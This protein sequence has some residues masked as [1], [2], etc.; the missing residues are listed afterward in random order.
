[1]V[2]K[3]TF[4]FVILATIVWASLASAFAGYYYLQNMNN[5]EQLNSA[6]SSLN[7]VASN[8]SQAADKYDLL[9]SEYAL[10][11]GNYSY[12]MGSNY[13]ILMP[14]LRSLIANFAKNYTS[15]LTQ[16][17]M[18][19]SYQQLLSDHATLLQKGNITRGDFG[20]LLSEYYNLFN[21]SAI[22]ELGLSISKSTTLSVNVVIDYGNGTAEWHNETIVTSGYT[23]FRLTQEIA[24]IESS[25]F[26]YLEPGHIRIDS[27]NGKTTTAN[28]T[29][30][31]YSWGYSW[32]WYYWN[33]N[34][35]RWVSGPVGCDAWLLKDGGIYKWNYEYWHFP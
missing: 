17:D 30:P 11:D 21:L 10:L 1:M 25:Y 28:Y 14:P 27:I 20:S 26:A 5:S 9:L 8:Y 35:K 6:Q 2:E 4:V 29:N 33:D 22:R 12:F 13:A 7:K 23:L 32:I 16:E 19:K 15:L 24:V 3:R 34:D 31:S 18:N